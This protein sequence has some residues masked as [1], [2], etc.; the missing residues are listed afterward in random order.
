MRF[1]DGLFP[2][3]AAT[4]RAYVRQ[5]Q[6]VSMDVC[7]CLFS[8]LLYQYVAHR[9]VVCLDTALRSVVSCGAPQDVIVQRRL[10]GTGI[11]FSIKQPKGTPTELL[12][13]RRSV[14]PALLCCRGSRVVLAFFFRRIQLARPRSVAVQQ[15]LSLFSKFCDDLNGLCCPSKEEEEEVTGRDNNTPFIAARLGF[16]SV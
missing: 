12:L 7:V 9:T 6:G 10:V 15:V 3:D 8:L 11:V 4:E 13:A 16:V 2:A 1:A 14:L 5:A